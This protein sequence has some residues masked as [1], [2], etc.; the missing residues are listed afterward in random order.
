M[1]DV[2]YSIL[3]NAA[4]GPFSQTFA[5][6]GKT[7]DIATAGMMSVTLSLGTTPTAIST[8]TMNTL[9]FCFA[10]SLA[11]VV[12]HTVSF[13]RLDGTNLYSAV[14]MKGGDAAFLRLAPGSYGAAAA[15]SGTR[16][17]LNI[18]ED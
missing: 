15:V 3:V 1:S 2:R 5:A 11:S 4:K 8:A 18:L 17:I 6:S 16:L 13:G 12:T 7:A 10:Q 9:G 14:Q